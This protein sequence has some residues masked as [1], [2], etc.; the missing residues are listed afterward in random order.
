MAR[1]TTIQGRIDALRKRYALDYDLSSLNNSNDKATLET[2]L[3][4]TIVIEDLQQQ[5]LELM[6]NSILENAADFKKINDMIRSTTETNMSLERALGID[7]KARK[8]E[9]NA[10]SP[11]DYIKNLKQT[12]KEFLEQRLQKVMCVDCKIQ[13]FKFLPTYEHTR[14]DLKIYCPQCNK[15]TKVHRDSKDIL[16]DIPAKDKAWR[17]KYPMEIEQART[18]TSDEIDIVDDEMIIG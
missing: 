7:R 10:E 9:D 8:T 17:T 14:F 4:N 1:S 13:L 3:R 12:A 18:E 5:Q 15:Y 6:E 2:I 11:A 16:Y